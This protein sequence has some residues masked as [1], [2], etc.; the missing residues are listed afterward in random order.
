MK[1]NP[2]DAYEQ[3]KKSW[4]GYVQVVEPEPKVEG[5]LTTTDI[6]NVHIIE[7]D[8]IPQ[9]AQNTDPSAFTFNAIKARKA[10]KKEKK[11]VD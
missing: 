9:A 6:P 4:M 1:V 7:Q 2:D 11:N 5:K 8:V 10:K 3:W